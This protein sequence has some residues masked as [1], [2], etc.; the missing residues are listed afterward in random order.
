MT[1]D[2]QRGSGP[3]GSAD[4][5]GPR[6]RQGS[7][8]GSSSDGRGQGSGGRGPSQG[9][10]GPSQG[11]RGKGGQG[12]GGAQG[13]KG[14]NRS[15]RRRGRGKRPRQE[16]EEIT[17]A[18]DPDAPMDVLLGVLDRLGNGAAFIRRKHTGYT[19][20]D[21]DVYVSPKIVQKFDLRS[22]DEICGQAGAS[23]RPGKSPPLR[24]LHTVNGTPPDE[25]GERPQFSRIPAQHPDRQLVLECGLTRLGQ[26]DYTNRII[27]LICPLGVGQRALIVAPSKAGKTMV[28]QAIAEGISRNYPNSRIYVL[29][30]DERP[31]E[32][33][34]MEAT[35]LGE[36]IASSFDFPAERHVQVAE[37]TL[38]R[39]RRQAELGRDVVLIL[40][41]ITRLARAYNTTEEGS[42]RTLTGG[43]DANSLE[44]PKRFFGSARNVSP[45]NGGGSLTIIATA[46]IDTGSRADQVIFEEFKG[47]GNSELVLSRDLAD[48]RIFPAIDIDA[49]ATRREELLLDPETLTVSHAMR[50]ELAGYAPVEAMNEVLGLM[51]QTASNAELV[52]KLTK[53]IQLGR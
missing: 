23:P 41:S 10:R 35:G 51:R 9:G 22:G 18:P 27:D 7:G 37:V 4:G 33:T 28:L 40:D 5:S 3:S 25:L 38:E 17:L 8:Q 2:N 30:V 42:G 31:E 44:K 49:S 45:E 1:E 43:I 14:G 50:R 19:P 24:H 13:G 26:P 11:G 36:V 47:T 12:K 53:R 20:S 32:V 39:A 21:E 6:A 15:R 16:H 48:R 29:L 46:L 52:A 34:E